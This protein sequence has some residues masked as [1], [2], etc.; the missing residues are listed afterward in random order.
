MTLITLALSALV[1]YTAL[2]TTTLWMSTYRIN[3]FAGHGK[4]REN[5][6][7]WMSHGTLR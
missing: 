2:A 6:I 7:V 3:V 4:E 5:I 1:W